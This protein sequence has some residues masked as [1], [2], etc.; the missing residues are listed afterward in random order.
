MADQPLSDDQLLGGWLADINGSIVGHG[1][2]L[3]TRTDA[4]LQARLHITAG[5]R[6]AVAEGKFSS[7]RKSIQF[8]GTS[9]GAPSGTPL[10][11]GQIFIVDSSPTALWGRWVA[12]GGAAGT[13]TF[14]SER[15]KQPI[16]MVRG[17][18]GASI[19]TQLVVREHDLPPITISNKNVRTLLDRLRDAIPQSLGTVLSVT[20]AGGTY[21]RGEDA[22][23]NSSDLPETLDNL[24]ISRLENKQGIQNSVVIQLSQKHGNRITAQS[25][26]ETWATG[27]AESLRAF[28]EPYGA[29]VT[30]WV[31][32]TGF[33][34]LALILAASITL[35]TPDLQML[36]RAAYLAVA[37]TL[38]FSLSA[39]KDRIGRT[40]VLRGEAPLSWKERH[41][42][43][44]L[45]SLL[46]TGIAALVGAV[47]SYVGSAEF[48]TELAA[49]WQSLQP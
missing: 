28:F 1:F 14:T 42:P 33:M 23:L 35:L 38:L 39:V 3:V 26:D 32:N 47:L 10:E 19:P 49:W 29:R 13:V 30:Q 20:L 31:K 5:D 22:W 36:Q 21:H 25:A 43:D 40:R 16:T 24:R 37:L 34:I 9:N 18:A 41:M 15:V 2:L 12:S 45:I 8:S 6:S 46:S 11:S 44:V 27:T 7:D 4:D 17:N 48:A